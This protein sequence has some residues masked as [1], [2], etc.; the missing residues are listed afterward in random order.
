[1]LTLMSVVGCSR[2]SRR[3]SLKNEE[4]FQLLFLSWLVSTTTRFSSGH[5]LQKRTVECGQETKLKSML[6]QLV[7]E[8]RERTSP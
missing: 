8:H 6:K 5:R 7:I 2:C 3:T 1:M 4:Q